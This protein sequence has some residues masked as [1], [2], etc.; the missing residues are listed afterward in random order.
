MAVVLEAVAFGASRRERQDGIK[1]IQGLN[2]GLLIDA[3]HGCVLG[4][5]QIEAEDV[6]GFGF[7]LGAVVAVS[8]S[9][10]NMWPPCGMFLRCAST[11]DYLYVNAKESLAENAASPLAV[12]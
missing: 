7:E 1:T 5:V 11:D 12:G 6:G 3:E 2:G 10:W 4:R 9:R 8:P